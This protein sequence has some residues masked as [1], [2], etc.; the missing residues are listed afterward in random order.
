[1]RKDTDASV[2]GDTL[3]LGAV[4]RRLGELATLVATPSVPSPVTLETGAHVARDIR[5]EERYEHRAL[6]GEGGMG[7]VDLYHDRAIGREVAIKRIR[8]EASSRGALARFLREGRVE[9]QLEHPAIVPVH[10]LAE[11]SEGT[12]FFTM[13]RVRGASLDDILD[14][15]ATD[16]PDAR[17]RHGRRKLLTAFATV[18]LA[19]DFA[20]SRGVL[21]RDLKPANVMLGDFGE[22]YVLDWGLAKLL[23]AP[24]DLGEGREDSL[25]PVVD[26]GS[27]AEQKTL[28]G[29]LMGTPGYMSPEQCRGEIDRLGP[30]SDV[31]A[32]GCILFE[33][34]HLEA[35]HPGKGMAERLAST[36]TGLTVDVPRAR[37]ADVPPELDRLWRDAVAIDPCAR[38]GSARELAE[39]VE[40]YLD[41]ERDEARRRELASAH[42][43]RASAADMAT[44]GGRAQAMR[45]LGRALALDP[46]HEAAL[47]A[48]ARA[49]TNLPDEVPPEARAALDR[50]RTER[51]VQMARTSAVR[52]GTWMLAIPAVVAF[53]VTS[54]ARGGALIASLLVTA[55]M[56]LVAWRTR[57]VSDGATLALLGASSTA[58]GLVSFVFGPFVLVPSLAATNAIFFAMNADARLRRFVVAASV[59]S[60]VIPLS[61]SLGGLDASYYAFE[62][63]AM[64]ITSPMV[65]FPPT[66]AMGLLLVVSIALVVTPTLIAGR[67]RDELAR[68]E[69]RVLL[70]A[71]YLAQLVPEAARR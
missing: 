38:I 56:A 71:H 52:L 14:A 27:L 53:G 65:A 41:G 18:C 2:D 5:F 25:P 10:D 19:V 66:L 62:A 70:Q 43:E 40:R 22:V 13:K 44:P 58:I 15:L 47:R 49:L 54:W 26:V 33:I 6:L 4:Q 39:R 35:L 32:L 30:A 17:A 69:E 11:N 31:Y 42:V 57:R 37:A 23:G 8:P 46:S 34:L 21:H 12:A 45:E 24:A 64:T 16:A 36:V 9:G 28:H 29:A 63:G 59:A 68:A 20:H 7:A 3:P 51:R 55:A 48:L 50:A 67:M 60:V 1:M 61:L